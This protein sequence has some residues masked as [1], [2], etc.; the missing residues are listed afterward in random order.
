MN[1]ELVE[2]FTKKEL[3]RKSIEASVKHYLKN[4]GKITTL[5]P[6]S[7]EA[8]SAILSNSVSNSSFIY[9][10]N[11]ERSFSEPEA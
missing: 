1:S 7:D 3:Q 4:G 8:S 9:L 10:D 2:H 6:L 5:T 11:E